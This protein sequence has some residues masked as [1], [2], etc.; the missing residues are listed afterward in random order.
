MSQFDQYGI[1]FSFLFSF[2]AYLNFLFYSTCRYEAEAN[3]MLRDA[4]RDVSMLAGM[5]GEARKD[6][7]ARIDTNLKEIE[8]VLS[9]L[10][11]HARSYTGQAR[12]VASD[13]AREH[14]AKLKALTAEVR[15]AKSG[16]AN[17]MDREALL[18]PELGASMEGRQKMQS[19][20]DLAQSSSE[21]LKQTHKV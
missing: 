7:A 20:T 13:K 6:K 12:A 17:S 2:H 16:A 19:T 3:D 18:S 11:S 10:E 5:S 21:R 8:D 15:R 1:F 4:E 9:S 14:R